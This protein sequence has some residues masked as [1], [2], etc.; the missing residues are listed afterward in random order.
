MRPKAHRLGI[1]GPHPH[2]M[3]GQKRA[4]RVRSCVEG[5]IWSHFWRS[6]SS[7]ADCIWWRPS[8]TGRFRHH[9]SFGVWPLCYSLVKKAR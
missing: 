9:V 8:R 6:R 4:T 7:N 3:R 1:A 5:W 2:C